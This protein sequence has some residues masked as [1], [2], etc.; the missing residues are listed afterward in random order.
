MSC[1]YV[2]IYINFIKASLHMSDLRWMQV[3]AW[4]TLKSYQA[5]S[6]YNNARHSKNS[7]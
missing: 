1:I 2:I 5:T 4:C 6:E 3:N 7:D